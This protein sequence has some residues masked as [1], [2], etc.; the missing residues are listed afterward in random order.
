MYLYLQCV[1]ENVVQLIKFSQCFFSFSLVAG[2]L[3]PL[4]MARP[5]REEFFFAASLILSEK[6]I[7]LDVQGNYA[8]I[9]ENLET[10]NFG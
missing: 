3:S 6:F 4:L 2:P 9:T 5:L 1:S 7:F 8:F 10:L